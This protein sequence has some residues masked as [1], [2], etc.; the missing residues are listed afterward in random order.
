MMTIGINILFTIL[1]TRKQFSLVVLLLAQLVLQVLL[2]SMGNTLG[3]LESTMDLLGNR[4]D[5]L[6]SMLGKLGY[7]LER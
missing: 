3:K 4:L 2:E 1:L 7:S 6:G 5:L